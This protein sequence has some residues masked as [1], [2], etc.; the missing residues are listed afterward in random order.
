MFNGIFSNVGWNLKL[1]LSAALEIKMWKVFSLLCFSL[2]WWTACVVCSRPVPCQT[3]EK[4]PAIG[5]NF[6]P[7]NDKPLRYVVH[8]IFFTQNVFPF[9]SVASWSLKAYMLLPRPP[10]SPHKTWDL[11]ALFSTIL[12]LYE[13]I[14]NYNNFRLASQV[15]SWVSHS[16]LVQYIHSHG[17]VL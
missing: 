16:N 4:Q 10:L 5:K 11:F 8:S 12:W 7:F 2:G 6:F 17:N 15:D 1:K 9:Y 3:N 14:E 13:K